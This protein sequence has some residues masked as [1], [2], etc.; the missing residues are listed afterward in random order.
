MY[1]WKEA[2]KIYGEKFINQ[3]RILL[4]TVDRAT[5]NFWT[6]LDPLVFHLV[7]HMFCVICT[8]EFRVANEEWFYKHM[9]QV[10]NIK[11]PINIL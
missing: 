5:I 8:T 9:L 11:L 1:L 6:L 7:K 10:H 2:F 4:Q 3:F